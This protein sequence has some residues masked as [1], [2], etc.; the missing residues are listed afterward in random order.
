MFTIKERFPDAAVADS[1]T[2]RQQSRLLQHSILAGISASLLDRLQSVFNAA[3]GLVFSARQSEHV[4]PL[5]H[6]LH[7]YC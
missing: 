4:T 6:D 3:A 2:R 7:W 5:L 1:N